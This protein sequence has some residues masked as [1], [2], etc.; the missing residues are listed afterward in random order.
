MKISYQ[1]NDAKILEALVWI[2]NE[3]PG[4]DF[5]YILKALFY[6]DKAHLQA[7]GRPVLGDTYIKMTYGPVA[8]YAYDLLEQ[9]DRLPTF[10]LEQAGQALE[11]QRNNRIPSVRARRPADTSLLSGSDLRCL[12]QALDKCDGMNFKELSA[13]THQERAWREAAMNGEMDYELFIDEDVE[14]RAEIV[15]YLKETS[16]SLVF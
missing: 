9:D 16:A 15:A 11:V 1:P 3:K 7:H 10:L 5:H 14:N 13:M 12:A 8:S 4:K 2:A 6:A